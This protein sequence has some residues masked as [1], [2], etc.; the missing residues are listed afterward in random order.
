MGMDLWRRTTLLTSR[1]KACHLLMIIWKS[2]GEHV[3]NESPDNLVYQLQVLEQVKKY[4]PSQ[5]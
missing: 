2:E 1:K 3:Q 5:I 4:D